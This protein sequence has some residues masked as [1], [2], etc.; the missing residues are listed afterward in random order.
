MSLVSIKVKLQKNRIGKAILRIYHYGYAVPMTK[1]YLLKFKLVKNSFKHINF[2]SYDETFKMLVEEK[3]SLCR[4]GDGE[5]AWIYKDSK[6]Y[7]GQENSDLLS[8]LLKKV[9]LSEDENILVGIPNFFGEMKGYS[10]N[11]KKSREVHLAKYGTRW[12]SLLDENKT[13][14][15]ALISRV[16]LGRN[17]LDYKETFNKWR[18]VWADRDVVIIEGSET[19]FGVGNDLLKNA[20]SIS[21]II[22][23]AENAFSR[24][25]QIIDLAKKCEKNVLF[26][27]ALGPTATVLAYELSKY[28]YQSIDIGHLDIEY[29]WYKA[30]NSK[31]TGVKGKYVNEA[32]G[33]PQ[34]ELDKVYL[35]CYQNQ[36]QYRCD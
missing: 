23:P 33:M 2:Y 14:V 25:D 10:E 35:D 21:R 12:M 1:L 31:K 18:K 11:R 27:I 16:Y 26:L 7:F 5:I 22:A 6:G 32:G 8:E 20:K 13:Y 24:Y 29:E 36:I 9:I 4:L 30:G 17:D 34:E 3:K 28:N 15:D 19:R